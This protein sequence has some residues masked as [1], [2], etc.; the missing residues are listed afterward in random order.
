[1]YAYT[2]TYA[3]YTCMYTLITHSSIGMYDSIEVTNL[4]F[5]MTHY[6]IT[7]ILCK[8]VYN[9]LNLL[10]SLFT[11]VFIKQNQNVLTRLN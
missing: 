7:H 9:L 4:L 3:Y 2:H 1:M 8:Y 11:Y 10:N 6:K 5:W